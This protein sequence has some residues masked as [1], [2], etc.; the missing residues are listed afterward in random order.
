MV[1]KLQACRRCPRASFLL[2]R[3]LGFACFVGLRRNPAKMRQ[4]A[5]AFHEAVQRSR[6]IYPSARGILCAEAGRR[7]GAVGSSVTEG[8]MTKQ[9]RE[10]LQVQ[11][12]HQEGEA[13]LRRLQEHD[14]ACRKTTAGLVFD[15][16]GALATRCK[17]P[18]G[19]SSLKSCGASPAEAFQGFVPRCSKCS[20]RPLVTSPGKFETDGGRDSLMEGMENAAAMHESSAP[21]GWK[22]SARSSK[23]RWPLFFAF[24]LHACS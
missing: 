5:S 22:T 9:H 10:A 13:A 3:S 2:L 15:L 18:V 1:G 12:M 21:F 23:D 7:S 11:S 20:F 16:G 14:F 6:A 17:N 4:N 8:P 19:R 24:A